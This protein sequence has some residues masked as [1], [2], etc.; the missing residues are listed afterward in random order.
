V[1]G[2]SP[3]Q[4]RPS[5]RSKPH[6]GPRPSPP[7]RAESILGSNRSARELPGVTDERSEIA[8]RTLKEPGQLAFA[9]TLTVYRAGVGEKRAGSA[10]VRPDMPKRRETRLVARALPRLPR[11]LS[12]PVR[13]V[14][15]DR[16]SSS[17]FLRG[18]FLLRSA[19]SGAWNEGL[20]QRRSRLAA[21]CCGLA[22]P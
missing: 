1:D 21:V 18:C 15:A 3:S 6:A 16:P 11:L 8:I 20:R 13:P 17:E 4:Y 9:G 14:A 12:R 2:H 19:P 10:P 22:L 7:E 5:R